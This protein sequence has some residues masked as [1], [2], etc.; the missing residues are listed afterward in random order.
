MN[1]STGKP[2]RIET[3]DERSVRLKEEARQALDQALAE[4]DAIDAMVKRSISWH[5]A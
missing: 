3:P 5:G 1:I 2:R 4:Q